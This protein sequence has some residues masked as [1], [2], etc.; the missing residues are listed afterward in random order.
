MRVNIFREFADR[1]FQGKTRQEKWENYWYYYKIPTF[2]ALFLIFLV[3][4]GVSQCAAKVNPD[5]TVALITDKTA[6]SSAQESAIEKVLSAYTGDVNRDGRKVVQLDVIY[7]GSSDPQA[8]MAYQTKL[9]VTMST[10]GEVVYITDD[11]IYKTLKKDDVQDQLKNV[12]ATVPGGVTDRIALSQLPAFKNAGLGNLQD[13]LYL[14]VRKIKG[15]SAAAKS[16]Q[17]NVSNCLNLV[18]KLVQS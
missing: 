6:V 1:V 11:S 9:S 7:M 12:L 13:Q 18:R 17:G 8:K 15:T 4:V 2:I 10:G 3:I 5:A 16:N 14:E